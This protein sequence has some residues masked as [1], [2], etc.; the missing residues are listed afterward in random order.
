MFTTLKASDNNGNYSITS[1]SIYKQRRTY[2]GE[3]IGVVHCKTRVKQKSHHG[4]NVFSQ[5]TGWEIDQ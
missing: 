2:R 3:S 1:G 4:K 5:L